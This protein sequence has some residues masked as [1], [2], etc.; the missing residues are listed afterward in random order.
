MHFDYRFIKSK[1]GPMYPV[2]ETASF[3]A[4][5]NKEKELFV[6]LSFERKKAGGIRMC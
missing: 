4:K 5:R 1:S 6:P 2:D 3:I